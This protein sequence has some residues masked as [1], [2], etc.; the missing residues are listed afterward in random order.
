MLRMTGPSAIRLATVQDFARIAALLGAND[1]PTADLED[2]QPEFLIA[3]D[4]AELIGVGG[5][6]RFGSTALLRSVAVIQE[7]RGSGLGGELLRHLEH[8]AAER[9]VEQ[10]IL[11]TETARDFFA[12][13]G[14][15]TVERADMPPEIQ[16]TSEFRSLCPASATC[17]AKSL[18]VC[19]SAHQY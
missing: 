16:A 9:G 3:E 13:H 17:M 15:Q 5:L 2:S 6:Q 1:L 10:L 14:Y 7:K 11:L 4:G 18:R 8:H 19:A 12:R